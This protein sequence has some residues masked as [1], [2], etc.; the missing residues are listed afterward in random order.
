[1]K[2]RGGS[3]HYTVIVDGVPDLEPGFSVAKGE[4][5]SVWR[6]FVNTSDQDTMAGD[7]EVIVHY[8]YA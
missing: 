8:V 3:R 2:P 5:L 7:G 1:M 4:K 6:R